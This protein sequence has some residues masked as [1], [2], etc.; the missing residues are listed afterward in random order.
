MLKSILT[1]A[2][3]ATTA[4]TTPP[5]IPED[6]ANPEEIQESAPAFDPEETTQE[7]PEE[8]PEEL[9]QELPE[10]LQEVETPPAPE[11]FETPE[12]FTD[13][14]P[15]SD[16]TYETPYDE[17]MA[18]VFNSSGII[19]ETNGEIHDIRFLTPEDEN[20]QTPPEYETPYDEYMAICEN[21]EHIAAAPVVVQ[22]Q[23]PAPDQR[24]PKAPAAAP[25][26]QEKP[27]F[28]KKPFAGVKMVTCI[29]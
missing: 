23:R 29:N 16:N 11:V 18:T 27:Y 15:E 14:P 1:A 9:P 21:Y 7:L 4:T 10:E 12:G 13:T 24:K 25:E 5:E 22:D 20:P 2:I 3:I 6:I 28:N 17:Y 8:L 26:A 19:E